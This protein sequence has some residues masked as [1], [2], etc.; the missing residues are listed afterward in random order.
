MV[1]TPE[2]ILVKRL[3][4]LNITPVCNFSNVEYT[5][6]PLR[7]NWIYFAP[8]TRIGAYFDKVIVT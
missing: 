3:V 2:P 6:S 4:E 7:T 5:K 8:L 1:A